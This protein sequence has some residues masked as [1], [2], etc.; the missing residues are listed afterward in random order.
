MQQISFSENCVWLVSFS[1]AD[2]LGSIC[3]Q[4][5]IMYLSSVVH[6]IG[7]ETQKKRSLPSLPVYLKL[8][9]MLQFPP[10]GVLWLFPTTFLAPQ[11]HFWGVNTLVVCVSHKSCLC[12]FLIR[13][14]A[15]ED[16]HFSRYNRYTLYIT[17]F[18]L[19]RWNKQLQCEWGLQP[20]RLMSSLPKCTYQSATVWGPAS[21]CPSL[22]RLCSLKRMA[23]ISPAT[24]QQLCFPRRRGATKVTS[25]DA[26]TWG[27]AASSKLQTRVFVNTG[28]PGCCCCPTC[29]EILGRFVL[30]VLISTSLGVNVSS[31]QMAR[32]CK[33]CAGVDETL[34]KWMCW[35]LRCVCMWNIKENFY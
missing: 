21:S 3:Y 4:W 26:L 6:G 18:P 16:K 7:K 11:I 29:A 2:A 31:P 28:G 20:A 32:D 30:G 9:S 19:Q 15:L 22:Q 23:A 14:L 34:R 17:T 13:L 8:N 12:Y 25:H 24:G 33:A 35:S 1:S 10:R 5:H 27:T